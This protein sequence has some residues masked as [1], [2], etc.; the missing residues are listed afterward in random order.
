MVGSISNEGRCWA[1]ITAWEHDV[2]PDLQLVTPRVGTV[3]YHSRGHCQGRSPRRP[4]ITNS[5]CPPAEFARTLSEIRRSPEDFARYFLDSYYR[6]REGRGAREELLRFLPTKRGVA[7]GIVESEPLCRTAEDAAIALKY[8]PVRHSVDLENA[9]RAA[10]PDAEVVGEMYWHHIVPPRSAL[11]VIR[12]WVLDIGVPS[13]THRHGVF[14]AEFSHVGTAIQVRGDG[15]FVCVAH[16]ARLPMGDLLRSWPRVGMVGRGASSASIIALSSSDDEAGRPLSGDAKNLHP[17][18]LDNAPPPGLPTAMPS[19]MRVKEE[20]ATESP[21]DIA[22]PKFGEGPTSSPDLIFREGAGDT[23]IDV[24]DALFVDFRYSESNF[25]ANLCAKISGLKGSAYDKPLGLNVSL[26]SERELKYI[27]ENPGDFGLYME[28]NSGYLFPLETYKERQAMRIVYE[29]LRASGE[30]PLILSDMCKKHEE[31]CGEIAQFVEKLADDYEICYCEDEGTIRRFAGLPS[32]FAWEASVHFGNKDATKDMYV[33][34]DETQVVRAT[35]YPHTATDVCPGPRSAAPKIGY[36]NVG[37]PSIGETLATPLAEPPT[38]P[39][40]LSPVL[41]FYNDNRNLSKTSL[42]LEYIKKYPE[43]SPNSTKLSAHALRLF[44]A[45]EDPAEVPLLYVP[46]RGWF[47]Y[48]ACWREQGEEKIDLTQLLQTRFLSCV[49]DVRATAARNNIFKQSRGGDIH[50]RRKFLIDLELTLS[51]ARHMRDLIHEIRPYFLRTEPMDAN[52]MLLQLA[53]AT[54][55]LR[56]NTIRRSAPGDYL[57]KMSTVVVPEYAKAGINVEEPAEARTNREWA[58]SF[59][60]SI[61]RPCPSG[62]P[63]PYDHESILGPQD[64]SNFEFFLQLLARL[65]EGKPLKRTVY[66][67][68]P[69][70]RN[71]KRPIEIILTN[72]LGTYSGQ[73]KHS[74]FTNDRRSDEANSSIT[75]SR[76][77]VRLL[78]GQEIDRDTPWCN[79]MYK[80]RSDCG[81]EG[82]RRKIRTTLRNMTLCTQYVLVPTPRLPSTEFQAIAKLTGRSLST[83]LTDFATP[84]ICDVNLFRLGVL[85]S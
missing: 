33:G 61:F 74:I 82:G 15:S 12:D 43:P 76:R 4:S 10:C 9:I 21:P 7:G 78:V 69:R 84:W 66:F 35:Y 83:Y 49:V 63:H 39:S 16:F 2:L 52:P 55:D 24:F 11:Q 22:Y 25:C 42:L 46:H 20:T 40:V 77:G 23:P 71:S 28:G 60:W 19:F 72:L 53:N 54:L 32:I 56:S 65:L 13:R 38:V 6:N 41:E 14:D 58:Y 68:S 1:S 57:T 31:L 36:I 81:R 48:N 3:T 80:R 37:A 18:Y 73:C 45:E 64:D 26:F 27:T 79:A 29:A 44:F 5:L 17:P 85:G 59:L 30:E 75:L 70:G 47:V 34:D 51:S 50:P 8:G 67:F 62:K